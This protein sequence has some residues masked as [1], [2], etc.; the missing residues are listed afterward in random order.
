MG[1]N[2]LTAKPT[3]TPANTDKVIGVVGGALKQ[4]L[5]S[6]IKSG[7]TNSVANNWSGVAWTALGTSITNYTT[8]TAPLSAL[9]ATTCTNL[10][11]SGASLSSSSSNGPSGIYNQIANIP[12]NAEL[13]TLEAGI[14]DFRGNATL[15]T[16][17]S[18][19]SNTFYGALYN[20][21]VAIYARCPNA[22]IVLLT[23]YG[24]NDANPKWNVANSNSNTWQQF[25]DA[26]R[27][28]GKRCGVV[29]CDVATDSGIGGLTSSLYMSDGIHL[30]TAG[31]I[32]YANTVNS[33]LSKIPRGALPANVAPTDIVL[34]ST[35]IAENAGAN[36]TVGSLSS[37]DANSGDTFTY[38]L[39][40]GTGSTD[41][42]SF[43]ITGSTLTAN[44][45]FVLATKSSY[46]IRIRSTDQGGLYFEKAFTISVVASGG[47]GWVL[48]DVVSGDLSY[49]NASGGSVSG[50]TVNTGTTTTGS[51]GVA[52]LASGSKN[53]IE[54]T[55]SAAWIFV[56]QGTSGACGLGDGYAYAFTFFST[57]N[58]SGNIAH[59]TISVVA[60]SPSKF[61]VA[62]IGDL[63]YVEKFEAGAWT[64]IINGVN[65]NTYNTALAG[66]KETVKIGL[67]TT[68]SSAAFTAVKT[69]TFTP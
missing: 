34:S 65:I 3:V 28:T 38:S 27:D 45:N 25:A 4:F 50:T 33:F 24:N 14:N 17:T 43:T 7:S 2:F 11:V 57:I 67:L 59:Q 51:Y 21:V 55:G 46:A 18:T 12:T 64:R 52:W 32:L 66:Y 8:Y 39:V 26:V 19:N 10:G 13:V 22:R 31:G 69:G 36:A 53:A 5:V 6:D 20:A 16:I 23:P 29:V 41:N 37:I 30:N 9:L 68:G 40:S 49:F 63:L 58:T 15:G 61:R 1:T 56:G 35:S 42:T 47:G 54:F 62:R 48:N 60:G 44:T